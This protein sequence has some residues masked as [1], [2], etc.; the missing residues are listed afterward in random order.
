[1]PKNSTF[2]K[3]GRRAYKA[4]GYQNPY[5]KGKFMMSRAVK[6]VPKLASDVSRIMGMLNTEKKRFTQTNSTTQGV[7][8]LYGN[9]S[10]HWLIDITPTP[11]QGTGFENKTGNQIKLTS[12]HYDFQFIAQSANISGN[13][14]KIQIIQV[15]GQPF[16]TVS[17]IMGKF[18]VNTKFIKTSGGLIANVYDIN[19]DRDQDYFNNFKVLKTVYTSIKNDDMS[20]EIQSSRIKFGMKYKNFHI[21]T[22]DNDPTLSKG[23][24]IMLITADKGNWSTTVASTNTGVPVTATNTGVA[25]D[26][27]NIHYFVDN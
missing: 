22:N 9:S 6:Q 18:I 4:T 20:G 25:F 24:L 5:K 10:G 2:K 3:Y 19:S 26:Y 16:S 12:S 7:A 21:R 27:D 13:R 23:Q 15:V 11:A 14:L 1:M 17:D 8:Q